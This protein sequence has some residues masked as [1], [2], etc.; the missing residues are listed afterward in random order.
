MVCGQVSLEKLHFP[1]GSHKS[2][3]PI[4]GLRCPVVRELFNFVK[5]IVSPNLIDQ[6]ELLLVLLL[7][8]TTLLTAHGTLL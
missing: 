7:L 2:Q 1:L 3:W 4:K 5:V 6:K 8:S